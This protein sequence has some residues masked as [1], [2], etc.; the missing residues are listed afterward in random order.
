MPAPSF[1][2]TRRIE[3]ASKP[4]ASAIS[5]AAAA[6]SARVCEG[7]RVLGSSRIQIVSSAGAGL[8]SNDI[9]YSVLLTSAY[10]VLQLRTRYEMNADSQ[11]PI[12]IS[13]QRPRQ[14][15]RRAVGAAGLRPRGP[16]RLGARPAR[17]QRR[18]QDDRDPHPHH[19]RPAQRRQRQGRRHRRRRRPRPG[20]RAHRPHRPG[21]DRRRPAQR[22][23]QPGDDRPP[24][25]PPPRQRPRPRRRAARAAA[26]SPTSA[27]GSSATSPAACA[28]AS[29]SRPAWSPRRRSSSST[30]RPPA[31]TRKAATSSGRCCASWS[32]R[33]RPC[34]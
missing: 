2:A 18:R 28:A 24:L 33:A 10:A 9:S 21:G 25:P 1:W 34:C 19:P 29:T 4:S 7:R 27:T 14:A 32:A 23:R 26:T 8:G 20:P 17:P 5:T 31:S 13:A 11:N 6:I 12:A 15:L 16:D 3:T 22:P 30:S